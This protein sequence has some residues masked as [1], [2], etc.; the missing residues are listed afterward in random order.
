MGNSLTIQSPEIFPCDIDYRLLT[1]T[2]KDEWKASNGDTCA[3]NDCVILM[4]GGFRAWV[5]YSL[6]FNPANHSR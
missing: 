6:S 2:M 5:F 1:C 4:T 3:T